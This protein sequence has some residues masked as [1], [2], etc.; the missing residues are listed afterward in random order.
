MLTPR[1]VHTMSQPIAVE[2]VIEYLLAVLMVPF[3]GSRIIEI[4]GSQRASY[5]DIMEE[6][7]PSAR[8]AAEA[9]FRPRSVAPTVQS[10][11]GPDHAHL[12]PGRP[13]AGGES[14]Q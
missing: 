13:Q 10:V 9:D 3:E 14:P 6:Y 5:A 8:P 4:G 11:A 1:W 12:R 2:D 7:G